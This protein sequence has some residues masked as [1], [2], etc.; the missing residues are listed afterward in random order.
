MRF[1]LNG[2]FVDKDVKSVA[3]LVFELGLDGKPVAVEVNEKIVA[4]KDYKNCMLKDEDR[5][6]IV[7]FVGGG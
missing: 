6:E 4:K 7:T 3:D 2:Q 5:V 1:R